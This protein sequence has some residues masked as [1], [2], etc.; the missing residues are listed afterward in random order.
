[1]SHHSFSFRR[2]FLVPFRDARRERADACISLVGMLVD[3]SDLDECNL[4]MTR[5]PPEVGEDAFLVAV[6]GHSKGGRRWGT[7]AAVGVL[8][9]ANVTKL[10]RKQP[11]LEMAMPDQPRD[12]VDANAVVDEAIDRKD[13]KALPTT[14]KKYE[15]VLQSAGNTHPVYEDGVLDR[16]VWKRTLCCLRGVQDVRLYYRAKENG[17]DA[18]MVTL[19]GKNDESC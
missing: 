5:V 10:L 19:V 18:C 4:A 12:V 11:A 3:R 15:E 16:D 13:E 1:M 14:A 9:A 2:A 17:T 6:C 7:N 8:H